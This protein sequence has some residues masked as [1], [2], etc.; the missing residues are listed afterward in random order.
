MET[1][2]MT[3][4]IH[5]DYVIGDDG[6]D[7]R[8]EHR[9]YGDDGHLKIIISTNAHGQKGS[10]ATQSVKPLIGMRVKFKVS[11]TGHAFDFHTIG[12]I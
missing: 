5:A 12:E 6:N 8:H 11:E 9:G 3:G 7:Y 10:W 4:I 1:K 2:E